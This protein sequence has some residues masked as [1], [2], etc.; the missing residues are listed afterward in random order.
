MLSSVPTFEG[1]HIF[2]SHFLQEQFSP[3]LLSPPFLRMLATNFASARSS[4]NK[5]S[6]YLSAHPAA[7]TV[8]AN[9]A[10]EE[11]L[12]GAD[13]ESDVDEDAQAKRE[14]L[15]GAGRV[16]GGAETSAAGGSNTQKR[17]KKQKKQQPQVSQPDLVT[18]GT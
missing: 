8:Q 7:Y 12:S 17:A 2:S 9:D 3:S 4:T 13:S 1:E 15:R 5:Y 18:L 16:S 14:R 11:P 10:R 6:P